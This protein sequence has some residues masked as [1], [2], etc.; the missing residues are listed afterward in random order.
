MTSNPIATRIHLRLTLASHTMIGSAGDRGAVAIRRPQ[1]VV[2]PRRERR[3]AGPEID[4]STAR[5]SL[6]QN[7][8]GK[9][10]QS[11]AQEENRA[12]KER[13][14]YEH[15]ADRPSGRTG[16]TGS[17]LLFKL[18]KRSEGQDLRLR[19]SLIRAARPTFSRR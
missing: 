19:A 4:K 11:R 8:C 7:A 13:E 18:R 10:S 15:E 3:Y 17:L 6:P 12:E 14:R 5:V 1:Q 16:S 9:R 2:P